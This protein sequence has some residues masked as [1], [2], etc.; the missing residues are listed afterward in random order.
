[1]PPPPSPPR[2]WRDG[3]CYAAL[4][5]LERPAFAWEWLRRD[6]RY[7]R[8]AQAFGFVRRTVSGIEVRAEDDR[9]SK[10]GLHAF[11]DPDLPAPL[12]RPVWRRDAHPFVLEAEAGPA[13]SAGDLFTL[14]SFGAVA[15][16][17][18]GGSGSEHL[19]LSDGARGVR[20][21][22]YGGSVAA[23]AVTLR[24]R[25]EG[26]DAA[27]RP[28]LALRRLLALARTRRFSPA[29]HPPDVRARRWVA[30][31]RTADA[32]AVGAGQREIA[33][34]LLAREAAEPRWRVEA[35]T[36]RSRAQRLVRQARAVA[37][38]GYWK[39]LQ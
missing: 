16:I 29:L 5:A 15:T 32:L 39:L 33:E 3:S 10:W 31:L 34:R 4:L 11:E 27:E 36:V 18:E 22:L 26:F 17:V 19:L 35:P 9:A 1:M 30:L 7:R 21:D 24:Y 6:E 37:A 2:D 8:D 25:L 14:A 13:G 12:A 23:G 20:L 38:D 28:M